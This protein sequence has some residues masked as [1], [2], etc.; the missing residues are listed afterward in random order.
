MYNLPD[1]T[2]DNFLNTYEIPSIR[3]EASLVVLNS[4]NTGTGRLYSGEGVF[5]LARGFLYTG[6][7]TIV[8]TL[9]EID[10]NIG[11]EIIQD[12]YKQLKKKMPTDEALRAAKLG[13]ISGADK[14]RAHPYFW[15]AY[16]TV[17]KSESI[18]LKNP[19]FWNYGIVLTIGLAGMAAGLLFWRMKKKR[20]NSVS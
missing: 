10:D 12:F 6:V 13:F 3:L 9:W 7:P 5:N 16:V 20:I 17:G 11:I 8:M 4:C 18:A 14:A 15:S 2:E 1:S 19:A